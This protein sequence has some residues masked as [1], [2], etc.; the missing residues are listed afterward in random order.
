MT[1][2][3]PRPSRGSTRRQE[4]L[5]VALRLFDEQGTGP[6]STNHIAQAAGISPGN[7]YYWFPNKQAIIRALF[8]RWQE[9]SLADLGWAGIAADGPAADAPDPEAA[10]RALVAALSAQA[11]VTRRF[12]VL[13][14][15]LVGLLRA[16]DE[17]AQVYR[18]SY[19]RR[20][21]AIAAVVEDLVRADL[22]RAPVPPLTVDDVVR[23][24]WVLAEFTPGFVEVTTARADPASTVDPD[25]PLTER[26]S[27]ALL[28]AH[29]TPSGLRALNPP[30]DPVR[31][32]THQK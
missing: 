4:I 17:I 9:E 21:A 30:A 3:T 15:E 24:A 23:S 28:L 12:A 7:L 5:E 26:L 32:G 31:A 20:V 25:E 18:G 14:R 10:V 8:E 16:D 6:V 11:A 29:L 22:M 1:N 2:P 13:A 27:A 19:E